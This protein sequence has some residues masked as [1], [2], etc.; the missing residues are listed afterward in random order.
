MGKSDNNKLQLIDVMEINLNLDNPRFQADSE[1]EI[2]EHYFSEENVFELL[3]DIAENGLSPID[4]IA[5]VS[6]GNNKG[7]EVVEGNRRIC[8]LKVL[9]DPNR[10]PALRRKAITNI[11][12]H[13]S[14]DLSQ[15]QCY[16][17]D[18]ADEADIWIARLHQ[19]L[20]GGIGRKEWSSDQKYKFDNDAQAQYAYADMILNLAIKQNIATKEQLSGKLST[21]SRFLNNPKVRDAIGLYSD[22]KQLQIILD[23]D[24][25]LSNVQTFISDLIKNEEINSRAKGDVYQKYAEKIRQLHPDVQRNNTPNPFEEIKKDTQPQKPKTPKKPKPPTTAPIF[26]SKYNK[27]L[28]N[29]LETDGSNK[30]KVLYYSLATTDPNKLHNL[31][32]LTVGLWSLTECICR[33]CG[34]TSDNFV[35][36][37]NSQM[38]VNNDPN[39]PRKEIADTLGMVS[40][41][42]NLVKHYV[43]SF[44]LTSGEFVSAMEILPIFFL[45]IL[46]NKSST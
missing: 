20:F 11:Q 18:N 14:R 33:H 27:E 39:F 36:F 9:N 8:A 10:A 34:L 15:V 2:I 40:Q 17:F 1:E 22:K 7:Y 3:K 35:A 41:K 42:G 44:G 29:I 21:A 31:P 25:F 43:S 28:A 38:R 26:Q 19:G 32:L 45:Y 5:V 4:L 12:S 6:I 23:K 46:N 16:V 13:L 24:V 30:L 37:G